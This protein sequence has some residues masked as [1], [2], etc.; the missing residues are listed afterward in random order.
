MTGDRP[1]LWT[2]LKPNPDTTDEQ[3]ASVENDPNSLP[4]SSTRMFAASI[5]YIV[6]ELYG[7]QNRLR[8]R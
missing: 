6:E 8:E 5:L 4:I 1:T 7:F 3:W 2:W